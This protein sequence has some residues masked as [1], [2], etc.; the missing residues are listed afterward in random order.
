[1]RSR[2]AVLGVVVML[3]SVGFMAK[4]AEASS[5]PTSTIYDS[6]GASDVLG[7]FDPFAPAQLLDDQPCYSVYL[8]LQPFIDASIT[9][10][11]AVSIYLVNG[12]GASFDLL[13]STVFEIRIQDSSGS[14]GS[15]AYSYSTSDYA[16][17]DTLDNVI[18]VPDITPSHDVGPGDYALHY[19]GWTVAPGF[20]AAGV[21][22]TYSSYYY[23]GTLINFGGSDF[24]NIAL[25]TIFWTASSPLNGPGP[26]GDFTSSEAEWSAGTLG[27]GEVP[28]I[29][30]QV[31]PLVYL[32]LGGGLWG[33][34]NRF[35]V[36]K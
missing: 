20:L 13:P 28:E 9:G 17:P 30:S 26:G 1:M 23:I 21:L 35:F 36:K 8:A 3:L 32:A 16:H 5:G 22:G 33:L 25:G 18:A 7:I 15:L 34:R 12:L 4:R 29:P 6:T 19:V 14:A 2:I 11:P 10:S 24:S 31:L 27:F